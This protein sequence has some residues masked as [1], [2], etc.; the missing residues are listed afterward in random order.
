MPAGAVGGGTW[1][2]KPSFSSYMW[3][4]AVLDHTSRFDMSVASSWLVNHSPSAGG[5]GG[6]SS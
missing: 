4:T 2:K 5:D 3:N 1:S 6:C